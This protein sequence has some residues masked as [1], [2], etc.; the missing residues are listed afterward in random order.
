VDKELIYFAALI[1]SQEAFT[2]TPLFKASI[3]FFV[4]CS[5]SGSLYIFNDIKDLKEDR[6]HPLK[7]KRPLAAGRIT[8]VQAVTG[9]VIFSTLGILLA[10]TLNLN[11]ILIVLLFFVLQ[12]A[13]SFWLKHIVILDVL[14]ISI[15]FVMRVAA[16]AMAIKVDISPWLLICTL[17]LA[18]FFS[19]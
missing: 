17:L 3:A 2:L 9:F 14:I 16:G 1:F 6:L 13:Y 18:L 12:I 4:F 10:L 15:G 5:L 7:S 8:R 19:T 11:F